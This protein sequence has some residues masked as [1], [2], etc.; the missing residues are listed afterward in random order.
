MKPF[1]LSLLLTFP[2]MALEPAPP[3]VFK[4]QTIDAKITVG[5]GL[6]IADVNGDGK[7]DILLADSGQTVCYQSPDWT[8]HVLTEKLTPKDHVCLCAT[9]L[10]GDGKAEIVVGAGW[11]PGDTKSSG[12]VFHLEN[13]P[14]CFAPRKPHQ[15][16][17]E[18]TVHRMHWVAEDHGKQFLAVLPLHGPGNVQGEG[19]G[20]NFL[21]YRPGPTLDKDWQTF[22]IHKGFHLAHNF[23]PVPWGSSKNES[24]LVACKEGVHLLEPS[25]KEWSATP[26]TEKGAGEVRLGKLPNG[27]RFIV[28]VEP[29]HGNEVVINPESSS[30]LWSQNR[31]VID[32]TLNQGHALVAG[33]FLGL[34]YDQVVAGWRNPSKDRKNVGLRLYVPESRD[35][36]KWKLHAT[37]DDNQMACED[38]KAADLDQDGDI[39]LIASGRSTRNV[40]IYWNQSSK[41]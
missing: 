28:T 2:A 30:R 18:P 26:M 33:D 27:K 8:K 21:G 25:K 39:D 3:A 15:L 10:T 35:G 32:D 4:A 36:S 29:M 40:I 37:I 11:N 7:D 13:Q 24:I 34:G 16:H 9:D 19:E 12:A 5:Y 23:D 22:L 41:E 1:S 14:D 17:H 20:I 6:A 31:L 38:L